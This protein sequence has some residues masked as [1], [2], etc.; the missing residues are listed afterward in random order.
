MLDV[1]IVGADRPLLRER[2]LG[3]LVA[4]TEHVDISRLGHVYLTGFIVDHGRAN[5]ARRT[6]VRDLG[7]TL[8]IMHELTE[9]MF[10]FQIHQASSR[11]GSSPI[12]RQACHSLILSTSSCVRRSFVRS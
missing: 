5:H 10:T 1:K 2:D 11:P 4:A 12:W 8:P 7:S 9:R 3:V 6:V